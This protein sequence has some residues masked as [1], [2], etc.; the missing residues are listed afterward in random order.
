[1]LSTAPQPKDDNDDGE[2]SGLKG[3]KFP[4]FEE[5]PNKWPYLGA[6]SVH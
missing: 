2:G 6:F 4:T 3:V 5:D 1:M